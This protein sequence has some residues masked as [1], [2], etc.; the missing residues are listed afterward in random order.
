MIP[1]S[2]PRNP[3]PCRIDVVDVP[4][5]LLAL[6]A[7][8]A[9]LQHCP[10]DVKRLSARVG[11]SRGEERAALE[12]E[13]RDAESKIG[14][15]LAVRARLLPPSRGDEGEPRASCL[16]L[17]RPPPTPGDSIGYDSPP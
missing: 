2:D 10:A 5:A 15:W 13:I 17:K 4:A 7:V 14:A 11:R 16:A 6:R 8:A 3:V 1:A 9:E 12:R